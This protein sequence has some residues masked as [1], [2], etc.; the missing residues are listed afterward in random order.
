[1]V[2]LT[3]WDEYRTL[4]LADLAQVM[5]GRD[6]LDYRN[7]IDAERAAAMGLNYQGLGRAPLAFEAARRG[8]GIAAMPRVAASPA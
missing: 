5:R 6:L 8:Q 7:I 3:E 2:I 1:V 4:D